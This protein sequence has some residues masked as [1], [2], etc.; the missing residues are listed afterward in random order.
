MNRGVS[1]FN[2]LLIITTQR[3][4][5]KPDGALPH[6]LKAVNAREPNFEDEG[7]AGVCAARRN[8]Y[9]RPKCLSANFRYCSQSKS[10]TLCLPLRM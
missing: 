2:T 1:Q 10:V 6:R 8:T 5:G 4:R 3:G 9:F 7:G